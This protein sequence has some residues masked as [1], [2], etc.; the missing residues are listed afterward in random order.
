MHLLTLK[1]PDYFRNS[2]YGAW[3]KHSDWKSSQ[4][5][6]FGSLRVNEA[7]SMRP[8][9]PIEPLASLVPHRRADG[10]CPIYF[11]MLKLSAVKLTLKDP[12]YF[13]NSVCGAWP[14]YSDWKSSQIWTFGSLRVKRWDQNDR[15]DWESGYE[16]RLTPRF[17]VSLLE[18]CLE[19]QTGVILLP[20]GPPFYV[21][22]RGTLSAIQPLVTPR[23]RWKGSSGKRRNSF[24]LDFRHDI[25]L[26][27]CGKIS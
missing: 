10:G 13:R 15:I 27:S 16:V 11:R 25:C 9:A 7:S 6:A 4:I 18:Y 17:H 20:P 5:W 2:A 24:A 8:L 3:P 12:D 14:K 19:N 1:D 21:L 26:H 22:I 23:N